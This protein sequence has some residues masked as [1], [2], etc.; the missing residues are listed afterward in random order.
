[1]RV[2]DV[3]GSWVKKTML[4]KKSTALDKKK[5][6]Q[7]L[8]RLRRHN[9]C[10][11]TNK[12]KSTIVLGN[13]NETK[14]HDRSRCAIHNEDKE[15]VHT[16]KFNCDGETS[17]QGGLNLGPGREYLGIQYALLKGVGRMKKVE[18]IKLRW[19]CSSMHKDSQLASPTRHDVRLPR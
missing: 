7:N 17:N 16:F 11:A 3:H 10:A 6:D 9:Q 14:T 15:V 12:K 1:M 18:P 13:R 4:G 19:P 8:S 2:S 5:W